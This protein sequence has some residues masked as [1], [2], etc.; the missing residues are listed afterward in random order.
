M[1]NFTLRSSLIYSF[2]LV[3]FLFHAFADAG[4]VRNGGRGAVSSSGNDRIFLADDSFINSIG[5]GV[6]FTTIEQR[7]KNIALDGLLSTPQECVRV[8]GSFEELDQETR[9]NNFMSLPCYYEFNQDEPRLQMT[10]F[11]PLLFNQIDRADI[12][13]TFT[14]TGMPAI[15]VVQDVNAIVG[16]EVLLDVLM[17]PSLIPGE[18]DISLEVTMFS[19]SDR[20]FYVEQFGDSGLANPVCDDS[21]PELVC[22]YP[23]GTYSPQDTITLRAGYTERLIILPAAINEPGVL[24]LLLIGLLRLR[25]RK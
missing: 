9:F 16:N 6:D 10:G 18:Y 22:G 23:P 21:L 13:W 3:M 15:S 24:A 11:G 25:R 12:T 20:T 8:F 14:Q 2:T 19:G 1:I 7:S 17:P 4:L 5:L